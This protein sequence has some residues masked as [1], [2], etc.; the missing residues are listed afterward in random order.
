MYQN[1]THDLFYIFFVNKKNT[2]LE[3]QREKKNHNHKSNQEFPFS[4]L[5]LLYILKNFQQKAQRKCDH[6]IQFYFL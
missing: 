6:G 4:I 3:D 2:R 5:G 1:P